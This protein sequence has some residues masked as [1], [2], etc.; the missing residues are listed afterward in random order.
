MHVS[1]HPAFEDG[2]APEF[3][4]RV[5]NTSEKPVTLHMDSLAPTLLAKKGE[6]GDRWSPSNGPST[7]V[8]TRQ[9]FWIG[10]DGPRLKGAN[11][12]WQ[13]TVI[14]PKTF[15]KDRQ[16]LP[17]ASFE[18]SLSFKLPAGEYDL[19]AGYGGG[20]H[21]GQCVASNLIAFDVNPEGR[22]SIAKVADR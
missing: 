8:V 14:Q 19:L 11:E 2:Q 15:E 3:T 21:A 7:A 1:V 16:L 18:I 4:I 9:S 12:T 6:G 10:M 20:V 17:K 22:A 5:E 13:W